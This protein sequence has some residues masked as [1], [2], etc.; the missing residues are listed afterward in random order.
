[1]THTVAPQAVPSLAAADFSDWTGLAQQRRQ[2]GSTEPQETPCDVLGQTLWKLTQVPAKRA[3]D[4]ILP[5]AEQDVEPADSS[6]TE[7]RLYPRCPTFGHVSIVPWPV[8]ADYH[9]QFADALL[10][11]SGISGELLNL[12]QNGLAIVLHKCVA[13]EMLVARLVAPQRGLHYD[14]L[15][16]VVRCKPIGDGRWQIVARFPLEI[17]FNVAYQLS[18]HAP[19]MQGE[20]LE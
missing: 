16:R 15:C 6:M 13:A 4:T 17:P 2:L 7:R 9:T 10:R 18:D 12:S 11:E 3:G 1:M 14:T 5:T 8:G 19:S 20:S